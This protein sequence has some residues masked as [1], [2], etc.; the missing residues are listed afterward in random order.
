MG[1]EDRRRC[2]PEW[3]AKEDFWEVFYDSMF[4]PMRFDQAPEEVESVVQL[5]ELPPGAAVCDFCCGPGRHAVA[6]AQ[7]GFATTGVDRTPYLLERARA[8]AESSGVSVE[9]IHTDLRTFGQEERFEAATNLYSSFGY[10]DTEAENLQALENIRRSLKPGGRFL[11]ELTP[12]EW[13]ARHWLEASAHP[14]G[15]DSLVFEFRQILD[16]WTRLEGTW[17]LLKD[18]RARSFQIAHFLYSGAELRRL[19]YDAGFSAV[20]LAGDYDG[21]PYGIDSA[22]LLAIA[23][24]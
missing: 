10:F 9:W 2:D 5:L 7:A 1:S 4:S 17:T 12:K 18:G 11:I 21:E 13:I 23:K 15:N 20:V 19:L 24:K 6:F 16:D 14:Q 22:K 3:F 8:H